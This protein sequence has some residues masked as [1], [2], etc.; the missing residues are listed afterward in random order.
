MSIQSLEQLVYKGRIKNNFAEMVG[1]RTELGNIGKSQWDRDNIIN[2]N[3][4][5]RI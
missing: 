3:S 2:L 5:F 1:P 4:A